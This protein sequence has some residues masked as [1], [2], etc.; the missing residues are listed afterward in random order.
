MSNEPTASTGSTA[1][2]TP[3]PR[4]GGTLLRRR[5]SA[6]LAVLAVPLLT[7][8]AILTTDPRLDPATLVFAVGVVGNA[9]IL[10]VAGWFLPPAG[11]VVPLVPA[12]HLVLATTTRARTWPW[13]LH[14]ACET[15]WFAIGLAALMPMLG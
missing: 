4:E 2:A 1:V 14:L 6:A 9:P 8:A 7:A 11:I 5:T 10:W 15:V 3:P 12:L 13:V